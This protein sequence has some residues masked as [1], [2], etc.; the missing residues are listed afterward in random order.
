[1]YRASSGAAIATTLGVAAAV[2]TAAYMM[3]NNKDMKKRA[4][5]MRRST[6]RA[7]RQVGGFIDNVSAMMR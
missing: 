7:L 1:M 5:R 2:G 4:K 6:G 3:S